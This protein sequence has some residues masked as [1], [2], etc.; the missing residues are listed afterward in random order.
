M[1]PT[2]LALLW[3][4]GERVW[5]FKLQKVKSGEGLVNILFFD[6]VEKTEAW[7]GSAPSV[8]PHSKQ[9]TCSVQVLWVFLCRALSNIALG[10][11]I[12]NFYGVRNMLGLSF[13]MIIT[14]L[15]LPSSCSNNFSAADSGR[16]CS[17]VVRSPYLKLTWITWSTRCKVPSTISV[18]DG[19]V[20]MD[21]DACLGGPK[22]VHTTYCKEIK[23]G[24]YWIEFIQWS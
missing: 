5:T 2:V 10:F 8:R 11:Q 14:D 1:H 3:A 20:R 6:H 17:I 21:K 18:S 22:S 19:N 9:V 24:K 23:L 16:K 15:N 4:D 13:V 7:V 12:L